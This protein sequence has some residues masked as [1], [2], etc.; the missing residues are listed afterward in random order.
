[1]KRRRAQ[2][3]Q[4]PASQYPVILT[5]EPEGWFT[6]TVP[7]LPGCVTHGDDLDSARGNAREAIECHLAS[8]IKHG[9][10]IAPDESVS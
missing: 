1:M 9:E 5:P 3:L 2:Q 6:V 8:M 10:P 4:I 7:A